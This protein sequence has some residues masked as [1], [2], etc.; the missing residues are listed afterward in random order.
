MAQ[1]CVGFGGSVS[2]RNGVS[3]GG[4]FYGPKGQESIGFSLGLFLANRP[5][6]AAEIVLRR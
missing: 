1:I 4:P 2:A 6:G 3:A 5:E